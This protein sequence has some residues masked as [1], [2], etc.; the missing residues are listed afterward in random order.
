MSLINNNI[1]ITIYE[2]DCRNKTEYFNNLWQHKTTY[3]EEPP[4]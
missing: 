1:I 2:N 4:L 3:R